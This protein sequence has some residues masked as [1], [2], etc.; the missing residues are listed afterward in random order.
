MIKVE[1]VADW[2]KL[3]ALL[4]G[5]FGL[6]Q[7]D[8]AHKIDISRNCVHLWEVRISVPQKRFKKILVDLA[9]NELEFMAGSSGAFEPCLEKPG[10]TKLEEKPEEKKSKG[11]VLSTSFSTDGQL[12]ELKRIANSLE[13]LVI[14][15]K[16][17]PRNLF[18]DLECL[19][20]KY[21]LPYETLESRLRLLERELDRKG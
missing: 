5:C 9:N 14:L 18:T 13:K 11:T 10:K 21:F 1:E 20:R 17:K 7:E 12:N 19:F 15:E 8:F 2:G 6:S 16:E 3:V 4:R